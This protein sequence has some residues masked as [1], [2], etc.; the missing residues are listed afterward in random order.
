M[1]LKRASG[2]FLTWK[3]VRCGNVKENRS[4]TTDAAQLSATDD[5]KLEGL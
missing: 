3:L 5:E 2:L 1:R 4:N